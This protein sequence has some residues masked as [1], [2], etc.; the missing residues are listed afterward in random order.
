[1]TRQPEFNAAQVGAAMLGA[2]ASDDKSQR[3]PIL[4][5]MVWAFHRANS[6]IDPNRFLSEAAHAFAQSLVDPLHESLDDLRE[7]PLDG[8][9]ARAERA[10]QAQG[11]AA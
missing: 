4:I 9:H 10:A 2:L 8:S 3:H 1:M 11:G 7:D 6:P 5:A